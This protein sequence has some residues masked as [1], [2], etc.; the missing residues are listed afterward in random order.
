[1]GL[2]SL[3]PAARTQD[4]VHTRRRDHASARPLARFTASGEQ[5]RVPAKSVGVLS[6][7]SSLGGASSSVVPVGQGRTNQLTSREEV[8]GWVL[9]AGFGMAWGD[10]AR[11][12]EACGGA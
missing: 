5:R 1:R 12:C 11:T 3:D 8:G 2:L 9:E 6:E 10:P 4:P 7:A